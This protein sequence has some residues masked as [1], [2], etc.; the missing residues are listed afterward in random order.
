MRVSGQQAVQTDSIQTEFIPTHTPILLSPEFTTFDFYLTLNNP[1]S[2]THFVKGETHKSA[3]V[4]LPL[5]INIIPGIGNSLEVSH[6]IR[7]ILLFLTAVR[8]KASLR[9]FRRS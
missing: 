4:S 2:S 1:Q 5:F 3:P 9:S 7:A 6:S 8:S